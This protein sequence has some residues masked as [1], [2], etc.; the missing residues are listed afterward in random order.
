MKQELQRASCVCRMWNHVANNSILWKTVRMKNSQV[1]NWSALMSALQRH[2]TQ[3]L[4]LRKVL[5]SPTLNWSDFLQHI[6]DVSNLES[7]DLCK[8]PA[9]VVTGLFETNPNLRILN[10][11]S[12]IGTNINL[13]TAHKLQ[14]LT[15]LRLKAISTIGI[16]NLTALKKLTKLR[17]LSLTSINGL[18]SNNFD[19]IG[20]LVTLESL[21]LGDC[22]NLTSPFAR[23]V[24]VKLKHLERLRLEKGQERCCTFEILDALNRLPKMAQL[25]LVNFDIK[26]GFDTRIA[27]CKNLRRILLIPTYISQSATTNN[28]ILSGISKLADTLQTFTWVVTQELLRVTELY[29]DQCDKINQERRPT[30]DKIPILKPVPLL[31]KDTLVSD[32]NA[33]LEAP[34]VEILPLH[35]VESMIKSAIPNMKLNILKVPFHGTWRQTMSETQ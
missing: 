28:M 26:S 32:Q 14:Q 24:L 21:E 22:I 33:V 18:E 9:E 5:I 4:D 6:G 7:I 13:S 3:H 12:I 8:C 29:V 19:T 17:H 16:E 15:E 1:N 20:S 27:Q 35:T 2:G 23:N 31:S 11:V 34:Q 25:E 10:A 30:E